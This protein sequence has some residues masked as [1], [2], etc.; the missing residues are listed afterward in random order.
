MEREGFDDEQF[1]TGVEVEHTPTFGMKT[2]FVIGIPKIETLLFQI[3]FNEPKAVY[4]GANQSFH[5]DNQDQW[6]QWQPWIS[7][8]NEV[9]NK[10]P[11]LYTTLDFDISYAEGIAETGLP[12]NDRFISMVSA[13]LPYVNQLGYNAVLK[14]D[15]KDFNATNPGVWCHRIHN[16]TAPEKFTNWLAYKDDQIV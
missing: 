14:I 5:L 7:M 4:F 12:E 16:L 2:L 10:C 9:L 1:F 13:K 15:D 6:D 11:N 8:I 3:K